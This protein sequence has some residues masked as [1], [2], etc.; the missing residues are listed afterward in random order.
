MKKNELKNEMVK[1]EMVKRALNFDPNTA[2]VFT[3]KMS[4][5]E[6]LAKFK[7]MAKQTKGK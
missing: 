1:N 4:R 3:N 7:Q 6:I 2:T 5:E